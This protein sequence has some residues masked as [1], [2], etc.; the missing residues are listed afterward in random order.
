MIRKLINSE[1]KRRL[2]GNFFSLVVL[3]GFQFLIPLITLPYLVRTIGLVNFGLVNFALSLAIYF[4][5]VIQFGF[6][7]TATREIA[8]NRDDKAKLSQIYSVTLMASFFLAVIS[9]VTF[10]LILMI[11]DDFNQYL[12]L[13][14]FTMAFVV[15]QS[16]FP[17]WFF[18]GMEDMKYIT[19]LSLGTNIMFLISLFFFVRQADD[20]LLVPLLNA[21]A[22]FITFLVSMLVIKKQFDV[23][24]ILP[25]TQEIK[26]TYKNG[27]NAFAS[28]LAP[29]LYNNSA[30]FL[31]GLFT[32]NTLVGLY[33]AAT[34]VIDAM[35]SFAYI[36]SN[37][38]LPYLSRNLHKHK[39]FQ[40][41]MLLS[42]FVLSISTFI[43]AE[44]ITV[45]L[46]SEDNLEVANYIQWLS[47]AIFFGFVYLTYNTNFLM[48]AGGEK[49]GR[50]ISLYVS[51]VAFLWTIILTCF[52]GI[53]GAIASLLL[54]RA[55]LSFLSFFFYRKALKQS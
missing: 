22:A 29:N 18:Q 21:I 23:K 17:I 9:I 10:G 38:F 24:F 46:F 16:L 43:M 7:I 44:W 35:I 14:L 1:D 55:A 54:A 20:F 49:I 27:Y 11:V 34:K 50:N 48:I 13:Y 40:K 25:K 37:T 53:F 8:R 33:T 51:S 28:Q 42:G 30:I 45:S 26:S 36:L 2:V 4:G 3:R 6:G 41:V 5:A 19:F 12:F 32:N 47:I 39:I 15:F 31:L 52:F